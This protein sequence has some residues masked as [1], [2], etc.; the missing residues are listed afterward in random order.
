MC[1]RW[2]LDSV[3]GI[4]TGYR[5]NGRGENFLFSTSSRPPL[6]STQRP[7]QWVLWA[8]S[9]GVKWPGHEADHSPPASAEVKEIWIYTSLPRMPSWCSA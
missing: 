2:S 7:I 1:T 9:P 8:L 6:G 5:L 4:A 3:V